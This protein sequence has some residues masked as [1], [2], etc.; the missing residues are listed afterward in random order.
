[1]TKE[2]SK[3]KKEEKISQE[4]CGNLKEVKGKKRWATEKLDIGTQKH[5]FIGA[6][7]GVKNGE[8][9]LIFQ[10]AK[11][12]IV[13]FL[14]EEN[15]WKIPEKEKGLIERF[16]GSFCDADH[17]FV[18]PLLIFEVKYKNITT[19]QAR[20]YSEEARMIKHIFPFCLYSLLLINTGDIKQ[21]NV[22]KVYMAGK[23]FDEVLFFD[24][25]DYEK[26]VEE[27]RGV[28]NRHIGYLTNNKYFRLNKIL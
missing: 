24:S 12:D 21:D 7:A 14:K 15:K 5:V 26:I 27:L 1:M 22:D 16:R 23:N 8:L 20:Q 11:Q 10:S 4:I 2:K 28:I 3:R 18:I 6:T 25:L 19:H 17:E 9:K 13:I